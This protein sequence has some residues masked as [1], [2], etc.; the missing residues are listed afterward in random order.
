VMIANSA[1]EKPLTHAIESYLNCHTVAWIS[2]K[3]L[4]CG[5]DDGTF[6]VHELGLSQIGLL[7]SE[8]VQKIGHN[9]GDDEHDRATSSHPDF[10]SELRCSVSSI[11][12]NME[13]GLL[14]S[15]G[16]DRRVKVFEQNVFLALPIQL[17]LITKMSN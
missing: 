1:A 2:Y 3:Q 4:A 15:V 7:N 10:Q 8:M 12:M 16:T 5:Y 11:A 17:L 14:A 6:E 13:L 9:F